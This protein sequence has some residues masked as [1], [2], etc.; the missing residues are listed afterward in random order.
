MSRV[1]AWRVIA[2]MEDVHALGNWA[3]HDLP[4]GSVN[5]HFA[6]F[7]C[8]PCNRPVPEGLAE[9]LPLPASAGHNEQAFEHAL[10]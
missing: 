10:R 5:E 4:H 2:L 1:C 7:P 9:T 6:F 8:A 3:Y